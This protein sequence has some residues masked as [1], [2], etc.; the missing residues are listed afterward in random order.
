MATAT[1]TALT[2]G[3][4]QQAEYKLFKPRAKGQH[5]L[6][7][8][9]IPRAVLVT[10]I[11]TALLFPSLWQPLL[12]SSWAYLLQSRCYNLSI[13]ETVWTLLSYVCFEI[14]Y[15]VK[16]VQNPELRL[17]CSLPERVATIRRQDRLKCEYLGNGLE[18]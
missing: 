5:V 17:A 2:I 18:S 16:F 14:V 12:S 11:L 9:A 7:S 6:R 3:A 1:K 8:V 4:S 13:F 15:N 10:M